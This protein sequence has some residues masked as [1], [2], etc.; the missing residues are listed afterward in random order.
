MSAFD[1][2]PQHIQDVA[3]AEIAHTLLDQWIDSIAD[4]GTYYLDHQIASMSG[5]D[6]FAKAF[7]EFYKLA[8]GDKD[9]IDV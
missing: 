7:N 9:Y 1:N 4:E 3:F 6:E 2:I 8:P 5:N